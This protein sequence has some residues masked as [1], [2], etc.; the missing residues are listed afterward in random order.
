MSLTEFYLACDG[1]E[2]FHSGGKAKPLTKNELDN[3][4][5]LWSIVETKERLL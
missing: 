5:E 4:M 2:E 3:L 1:L